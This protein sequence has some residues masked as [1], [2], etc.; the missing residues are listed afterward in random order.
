MKNISFKSIIK[1]F[2]TG[3]FFSASAAFSSTFVSI[4]PS[5]TETI[6]ALNAQDS[7]LAVSKNC[8]YPIEATKKEKIG[9]SFLLNEE[10][11][12]KLKPNYILAFDSSMPQLIKFKKFNIIPICLKYNNVDSIIENIKKIAKLA[13]K[14]AQGE[15]LAKNLQRKIESSNKHK[16]KKILYVVQTTPMIITGKTSFISDIIKKSGNIPIGE[17]LKFSYPIISEEYAIK[18]KPDV[19]VLSPFADEKNIKIYFPNT[20]TVKLTL[21]QNDIINRPSPRI[22]QSVEFFANL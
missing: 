21:E 6:Y 4:S 18:K 22:Y 20:K 15:I 13:S 7:L 3:V 19:I 1:L 9:T 17:E 10:K 16:N 2:L 12:I 5:M 14:E 8:S 11:I